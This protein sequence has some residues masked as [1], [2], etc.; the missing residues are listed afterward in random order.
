M[1]EGK[2][3]KVTAGATP[4]PGPLPHTLFLGTS[5]TLVSGSQVPSQLGGNS[6]TSDFVA[7]FTINTT[8]Q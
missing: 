3:S 5:W 7:C 6:R 4:H 2:D 8:K 1:K